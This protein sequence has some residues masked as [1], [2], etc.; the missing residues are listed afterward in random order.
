MKA[1]EFPA[2][3]ASD[4]N[5]TLPDALSRLLMG[6]Q[7]VRVLIL[8]SEPTDIDEQV[9]WSQLTTEQFFAGYSEVDAVY[10]TLPL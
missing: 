9:A 2:K 4:G 6:N 8:V 3:V 10:D 1:Y 5:L 7:A